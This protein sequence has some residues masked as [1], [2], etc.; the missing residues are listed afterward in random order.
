MSCNCQTPQCGCT[1]TALTSPVTTACNNAEP[2]EEITN[3]ECVKYTGNDIYTLAINTNDRLDIVIKKL[4]TYIT[5]GY[6][7]TAPCQS[8]YDFEIS[9][10]KSTEATIFWS[11]PPAPAATT[12]VQLVYW[13]VGQ[14]TV[15]IDLSSSY[16]QWTINN[17]LA[18]T[19]YYVRIKSSTS[20]SVD[21]CISITLSFKTLT[22]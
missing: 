21:C 8:I 20:V 16:T 19:T 6:N 13:I 11:Y 1:E 9:N 15:L 18:N 4:V 5:Q 22:V 17:L 3:F 12:A 2:C 14:P 7:P 10:I